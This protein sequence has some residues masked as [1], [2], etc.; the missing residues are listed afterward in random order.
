M[1]SRVALEL[2]ADLVGLLPMN[3]MYGLLPSLNA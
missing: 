3:I 2:S 1:D